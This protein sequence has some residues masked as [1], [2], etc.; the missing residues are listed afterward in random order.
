MVLAF[1]GIRATERRLAKL[2]DCKP[3]WHPEGTSAAGIVRAAK[4][5][6]LKGHILDQADI[7]TLKKLVKAGIP[8]IVNWFSTN[9]GHYSVVVA[10]TRSHVVLRDPE[11]RAVQ[12]IPHRVFRRIWFDFSGDYLHSPKDLILRRAIVVS[13]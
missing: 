12:R 5:Y 11:K 8:P 3:V 2:A 13:R 1:Y 7:P 6:D 4:Q 9:E 10:V